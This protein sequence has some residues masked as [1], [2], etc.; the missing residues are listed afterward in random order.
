MRK[1]YLFLAG[2]LLLVTS[3]KTQE[4]ILYFQDVQPGDEIPTQTL[5]ALSFQP[6]DKINIYIASATTPAQAKRFNLSETGGGANGNTPYII[7]E[8]G[9]V[10]IPG[11]GRVLIGGLTRA[12]AVKRISD[13]LHK[14]ILNDAVVTITPYDRYITILGEVNRPGRIEI[15]KDHFTILEAIGAANDLT[16][17]ANRDPILVIRQ[18]G[19]ISKTYSINLRSKELMSSPVYN[20]KPNDVI[21]VQ[22]NTVRMAQSTFNENSFRQVATWISLSSLLLSMG[23]LIFRK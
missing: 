15:N 4:K 11:L 2:I 22:P 1:F 17:Q 6:G 18:E 13:A 16:I 14:G 21:Y 7:D 10:E 9:V 5:S 12:E 8:N 19:D 20:L 3:C 23:I